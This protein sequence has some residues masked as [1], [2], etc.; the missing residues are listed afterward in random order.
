MT[1]LLVTSKYQRFR[2]SEPSCPKNDNSLQ[3]VL[4]LEDRKTVKSL[5]PT[6]RPKT[7]QDMSI[8]WTNYRSPLD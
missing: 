2:N 5:Y 8:C 4:A 1:K 3:F 6:R 7:T